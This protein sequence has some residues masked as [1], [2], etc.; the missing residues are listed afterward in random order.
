MSLTLHNFSKAGG[1][2]KYEYYQVYLK[3]GTPLPPLP[4]T[5][6]VH[7]HLGECSAY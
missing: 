5:S 3:E 4:W 2:D 1:A 7:L 6:A